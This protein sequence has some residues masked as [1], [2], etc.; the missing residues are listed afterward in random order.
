M[1]TFKENLDTFPPIDDILRLELLDAS[2]NVTARIENKPGS[3]GSVR[4]YQHLARQFGS[5]TPEA[6]EHGIALY[7]EHTDDAL[8]NPGKHPN[9]D[10]L[11]DLMEHQQ[12][13]TVRT[14]AG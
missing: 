12:T 7:A 5:I 14:I 2:G 3:Q 6:A 11:L 4:L 9:I 1:P 13:L 10:R 8:M